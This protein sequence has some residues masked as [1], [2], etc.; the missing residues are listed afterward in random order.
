[1]KPSAMARVTA[2]LQDETTAPIVAALMLAGAELPTAIAW[3]SYLQRTML[4]DWQTREG[5]VWS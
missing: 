5:R 1:M 3:C 2:Y 4:R